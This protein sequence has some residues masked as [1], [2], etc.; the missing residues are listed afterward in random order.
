MKKE[1]LQEISAL[2][3]SVL[4][5]RLGQFQQEIKSDLGEM[6]AEFKSDMAEMRAEFKSDMAEM[7]TEFDLKL[8]EHGENIK[9]EFRT[10]LRHQFGIYTEELRHQVQLLAE[11]HSHLAGKIGR[12][13]HRF[14]KTED[15]LD[16]VA[17]QLLAHRAD[18]EKHTI[19]Q[20]KEG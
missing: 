2:V 3:A 16:L 17:T 5:L 15:R 4:D 1:D 12:I 13:D 11:G 18:T 6:R 7:R 19:Y 10:E 8:E 9:Q 14:G 20:V